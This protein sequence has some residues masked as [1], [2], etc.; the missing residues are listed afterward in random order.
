MEYTRI[1][2][3]ILYCTLR[4]DIISSSYISSPLISRLSYIYLNEN[5]PINWLNEDWLILAKLCPIII[6]EKYDEE[7]D[8]ESM[9]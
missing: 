8:N 1:I 7:E 2:R 6:D 9:I 5:I 3:D 4:E